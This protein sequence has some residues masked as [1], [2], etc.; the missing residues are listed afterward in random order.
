MRESEGGFEPY[1]FEIEHDVSVKVIIGN[2]EHFTV[3]VSRDGDV[4]EEFDVT[5]ATLMSIESDHLVLR[6]IPIPPAV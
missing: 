3:T 2:G 1:A 5:A 6:E 4:V